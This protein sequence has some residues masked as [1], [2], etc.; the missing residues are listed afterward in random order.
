MGLPEEVVLAL[1][2]LRLLPAGQPVNG[3][4]LSGGV[5]SDI[6]RVDLPDGPVCVKR[7]VERLRVPDT[8]R[9]PTVRTRYEAEWLRAVGETEPAAA[10]RV[11]GFSPE[12]LV[13]VLEWLDPATHPSWKSQLLAGEVDVSVAATLGR[14]LARVHGAL[15]DE[16]RFADRFDSLDLFRALRLRPYL[17][18]TAERHPRHR[19]T[20][21]DLA[22]RTAATGH[23]V[24]HGDVS[25]KNILVGPSGPV[26]IDA[27]CATWGD[28]AFDLA[29]CLNHLL[30]KAVYRPAAASNLKRAFVALFETY[31]TLV[32][33]EPASEVEGRAATLLPA[34]ALAR[35]DGSSP[36]EYLDD[37]RQQ[38]FVRS[39]AL[40]L[41]ADRPDLLAEIA[42]D[43]YGE[44]A[45]MIE[46]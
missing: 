33:W 41:I 42:D 40:R 10:C 5:S 22:K 25:P 36:V 28:P 35:V 44:A 1:R 45:A 30:L 21:K 2:K 16:T 14:R 43:W 17:T 37:R 24:I 12:H 19:K 6:W 27:E 4:P 46:R 38:P 31:L 15:A 7:A 20:L 29:F 26:M 13:L 18:V 8:W 11:I 32:S 34:L 39:W 3:W 23:T 9:V